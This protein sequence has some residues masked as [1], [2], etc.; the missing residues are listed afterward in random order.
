MLAPGQ[1]VAHFELVALIGRGGMG[2]VWRARDLRLGREVALKVL[3]EQFAAEPERVARFQREARVLAALNH[4]HVAQL[5]ELGEAHADDTATLGAPTPPALHFLVMELVEGETLAER[6][7]RGPLALADAIEMARQVGEG[8]LAA[9]GRGVI[10]RDLKPANIVITPEGQA[11]ILDFGLARFRPSTATG[12]AV[13]ITQKLSDPGMVIGTAAYMAPEQVR[14]EE[15]DERCDVWAFA[16]C[17]AEALTG[18]RVFAGAT[19]PEIV[20][21]VLAGEADLTRLPP[22]TPRALR[23]LLERSLHTGRE[24]RPSLSEVV[25]GVGELAPQGAPSSRRWLWGAALALVLASA[26]ALV[27]GPLRRSPIRASPRIQAALR[28]AVA[29]EPVRSAPDSSV[30][31]D[32]LSALDGALLQAVSSSKSLAVVES[33]AADVTVHGLVTG[34]AQG[35]RVRLS[36]S[37]VRSGT[38]LGVVD[39][40]LDPHAGGDAGRQAAEALT[41]LLEREQ[42]ARELD[43]SDA[44]HGFLARR[45]RNLEAAGAFRDGLRLLERTRYAEVSSALQRA[46]VADPEFW[47][48][49]LYLAL[50]AKATSR[51][52]EAHREVAEAQRL[53]AHPDEGEAAVIEEVA[54]TIAEDSQRRLEALERARKFFPTSGE[55]TY[56]LAQ[57]Y[58]FQDRP[59]EAIPLLEELI[60]A[61]W[62]PDWSPTREELAFCQLLAGHLREVLAT[63]AAG[64]ERFPT[65][66]RYSFYS[67]CALQQLGRTTEA[68]EALRQA[69]RK[70]LD[71][72]GTPPLA[73]HQLAAYWASLLRWDDERRTQ[74][75]GVLTEAERGLAEKPGAAWL[76]QARAEAL[77]GLG[78][79]AEAKTVLEPLARAPDADPGVFL[80]LSRAL[81]GLGDTAGARQALA[82]A[83]A[84]WREG[85]VPALGTLAYNIAAGWAAIGDSGRSLDWLLRARDQYGVDR[86]DLAMDPDLDL[87]RRAGLLAQLPPRR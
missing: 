64:E 62:R 16:C 78:R 15:C 14:G 12:P 18:T 41:S 44:L 83:A 57:V 11:K 49:H 6:L 45:A 39:L 70:H 29:L 56:G 33:R 53:A 84:D 40:P 37:G 38:V 27:L 72:T 24:K 79:V 67:A 52:D 13:D 36:P 48:A 51:F 34:D 77:V 59:A 68:R 1:R 47:P 7:A 60:A 76:L 3:P 50:D 58:R 22:A 82:G 80:A 5:F 2:E 31:S 61:D 20:G 43:G 9:H 71:F 73:A 26:L 28:L 17:V 21:K 23:S 30:P 54:A 25:H 85:H 65:R 81:I 75:E 10:H 8:L 46:L 32:V 66:Y 74:W 42:V 63:A 4:P 35:M 87:L 86:L 19:V 55:L 69:I